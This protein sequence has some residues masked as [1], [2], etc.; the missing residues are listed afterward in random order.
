MTTN[1]H[2]AK[3]LIN[4]LYLYS[5]EDVLKGVL[6]AG[7][8][9]MIR[10]LPP[11]YGTVRARVAVVHWDFIGLLASLPVVLPSCLV[12]DCTHQIDDNVHRDDVRNVVGVG[13]H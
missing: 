11:C 3:P 5:H 13:V 12:G 2:E 6:V 10:Q 9:T 1:I 7:V 8:D 4:I